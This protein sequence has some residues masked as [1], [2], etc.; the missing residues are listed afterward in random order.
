LTKLEWDYTL[1]ASTY[2]SRPDY[3]PAAVDRIVELAGATPG[4]P[5]CDVGAGSGHLTIPLLQRG[6]RVDAVEP[7]DAMRAVGTDRTTG[8]AGVRWHAATAEQTGLAAAS[9]ALV[10]FGSSFN[11]T[12][13]PAA[14]AETDRLLRTGGWFACLWNHRVLDDPLQAEIESLIKTQIP[15]YSYG[16]R[17]ADQTAVIDASGRFGPVVAFEETVVNRVPTKDW[18]AAWRSHATLARQAGDRFDAVV[19]AIEALIPPGQDEVTV[20]YTTRVFAARL[21]RKPA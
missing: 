2:A 12:D 14:L 11:V 1:L 6:L 16:S 7:N 15:D 18:L 10:T 21:S 4:T 5:A 20:P 19:D 17:R 13:R 3:A 8:M 9:F